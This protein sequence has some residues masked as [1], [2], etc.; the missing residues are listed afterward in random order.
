MLSQ[1]RGLSVWEFSQPGLRYEHA[2]VRQRFS[3]VDY[4]HSY[5]NINAQGEM[6]IP[7]M[8]CDECDMA[9]LSKYRSRYWRNASSFEQITSTSTRSTYF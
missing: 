1:P 4:I 3:K 8:L 6:A 2:S 9:G 5:E 7:S